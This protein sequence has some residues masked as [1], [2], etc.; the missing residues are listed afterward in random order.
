MR[1]SVKER[2]IINLEI[3]KVILGIRPV[4]RR[5]SHKNGLGL[6]DN[7]VDLSFYAYFTTVSCD[8]RVPIRSRPGGDE[9]GKKRWQAGYL[10]VRIHTPAAIGTTLMHARLPRN[11]DAH[12]RL[13]RDDLFVFG[14][15]RSA[16][17]AG[18]Y[19]MAKSRR[20]TSRIDIHKCHSWT[21]VILTDWPHVVTLYSLDR[22][23]FED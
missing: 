16:C 14:V 11:A 3:F 2:I 21:R 13:L 1:L 15:V 20:C 4:P 18:E 17:V 23:D 19:S 7:S 6:Y 22:D 12:T 5:W 10:Y 9:G 8:Y